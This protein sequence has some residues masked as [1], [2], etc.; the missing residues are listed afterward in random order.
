MP[1]HSSLVRRCRAAGLTA[2]LLVSSPW[3]LAQ[4]QWI[5]GTGR[6]V[7]SDT[8]P[9]SSIPEKNIVKSPASARAPV[10]PAPVAAASAPAAAA[11]QPGGAPQLPVKDDELEARK[12]QA[13]DAEQARRK[14]EEQKVAK[15]RAE[16]CEQARKAKAVMDSGTRLATTNAKG[17]REIMDDKARA[18]EV[19]RMDEII[20]ANCG[21]MPKTAAAQ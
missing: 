13:E 15:S 18:A 11:S 4:W 10:A 17:E 7:F 5:D 6:K 12:K 1:Q 14:A 9:P 19:R 21:P 3:A 2:L 16:S 8:A 20:R